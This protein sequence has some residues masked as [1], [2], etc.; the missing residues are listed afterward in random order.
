ME[1]SILIVEDESFIALSIRLF[2]E[3]NNYIVL[4][5]CSSA[6]DAW[7]K[8]KNLSP[9]IVLLDI[10][11]EGSRNGIWLAKKIRSLGL[12]IKI[13][14]LTGKDDSQILSRVYKTKPEIFLTKPFNFKALLFN[15]NNLITK[16]IELKKEKT[17]IIQEG[18]NSYRINYENILYIMSEGNYLNILL[19]EDKMIVIRLKIS[20]IIPILP[21]NKFIRTHLRYIAN[22]QE[23]QRINR[24]EIVVNNQKLPV[25]KP[26]QAAV[27]SLFEG[28][29]M[30]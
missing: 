3:N 11:L 8:C 4:G 12:A 13:V 1:K 27:S 17:I 26:Y 16:S 23:I 10:D 29:E 19:K 14:F 22:I 9:S 30:E 20:E 21:P 5:I 24:N 25:S 18:K 28:N 2:L 6:E 7:E 15:L